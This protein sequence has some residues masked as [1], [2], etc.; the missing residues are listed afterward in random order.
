MND[1]FDNYSFPDIGGHF[2]EY[3][4]KFVPETLIPALEELESVYN[5][6]K[7]DPEFQKGI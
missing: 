2:K 5:K 7:D 1:I 3:G 4:G 6:T